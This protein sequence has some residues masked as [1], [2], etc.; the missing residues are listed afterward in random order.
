MNYR[1]T[2]VKA[3]AEIQFEPN[4][5]AYL[6]LT[7]KP[8]LQLRDRLGYRLFRRGLIAAREWRRG[9][10]VILEE[11]KPVAILES[12]AA[13]TFD[14]LRTAMGGHETAIREDMS[15]ARN[16]APSAEIFSL[17]I[18]THVL[19]PVPSKLRGL[20]KYSQSIAIIADQETARANLDACLAKLGPTQR[21]EFGDGE[22]FG[23]RVAVEGWL[24]GPV[25]GS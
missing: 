4:E 18:L 13:Y 3:L 21:R 22:A 10:L 16:L 14:M 1:E 5:L 9:D 11:G 20:V 7:S 12:K 15:K 25:T 8:E 19:N 6:A 23:V 2:F 24:C 17:V